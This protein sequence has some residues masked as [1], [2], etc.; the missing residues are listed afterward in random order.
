MLERCYSS[1]HT[2]ETLLSRD[3]QRIEVRRWE[4]CL[5]QRGELGSARTHA[6]QLSRT[7][8]QAVPER[9]ARENGPIL[10]QCQCSWRNVGR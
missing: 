4:K 1:R 2:G 6:F 7:V 10:R 8:D 9:T 3:L 5:A